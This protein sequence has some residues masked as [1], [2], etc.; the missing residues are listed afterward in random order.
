MIVAGSAR[1]GV[2]VTQGTRTVPAAFPLSVD[3]TGSPNVRI[4]KT[5]DA[6]GRHIA[7]LDPATG[8]L[9]ALRP[10]TVALAVTV[11]GVTRQAQVRIAAGAVAPAA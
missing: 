8:T 4:G 10:G 9:T 11:N 5:D 3:W 6:R 1:V 7:T 2:Q